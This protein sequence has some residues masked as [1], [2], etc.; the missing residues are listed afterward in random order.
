MRFD[1]GPDVSRRF[2][3]CSPGALVPFSWGLLLFSSFRVLS[4]PSRELPRFALISS[5]DAVSVHPFLLRAVILSLIS[6]LDDV[7]A[8]SRRYSSSPSLNVSLSS[9]SLLSHAATVP[10]RCHPHS[11]RR[12]SHLVSFPIRFY[13]NNLVLIRLYLDTLVP[14]RLCVAI[15]IYRDLVVLIISVFF[16][17]QKLNQTSIH[18]NS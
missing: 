7:S 3:S 11:L 1:V 10:S 18:R 2:Q 6:E 9:R 15:L 17:F 16:S 14:I 4:R 8:A 5:V 12:A 13:R